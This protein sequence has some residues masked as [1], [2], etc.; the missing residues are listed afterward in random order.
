MAQFLYN[1]F[2][3]FNLCEHLRQLF[4]QFLPISATRYCVHR[5]TMIDNVKMINYSLSSAKISITS[6]K[7]TRF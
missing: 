5:I 2:S 4:L 7:G 3:V 1:F 6:S